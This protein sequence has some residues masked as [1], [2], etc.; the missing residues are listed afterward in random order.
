M[1]L[2]FFFLPFFFFFFLC[3]YRKSSV[4]SRARSSFDLFIDLND[5]YTIFSSSRDEIQW[6]FCSLLFCYVVVVVCVCVC[7]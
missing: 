5:E 4:V 6:K 2:L 1:L 7:I 3:T